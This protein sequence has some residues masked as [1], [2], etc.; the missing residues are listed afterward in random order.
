MPFRPQDLHDLDVA[1][2]VRIET[3]GDHNRVHSTTIWIVVDGAEVFVRSVRGKT[4]RWYQE[5]L[6][7]PEVTIDDRGRRLEMLAVPVSD[8]D[9]V[10]RVSAALNR[11]YTYDAAGL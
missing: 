8:E 4:G 6:A 1:R 10:R 2:D 11:K 7:H 3:H 5:A 9:S